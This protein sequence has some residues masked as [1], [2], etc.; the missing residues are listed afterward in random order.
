MLTLWDHYGNV[1]PRDPKIRLGLEIRRIR[2]FPGEEK[3]CPFPPIRD[4]EKKNS[5]L[6]KNSFLN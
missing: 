2:T 6:Q 3:K 1:T 5:K 4:L